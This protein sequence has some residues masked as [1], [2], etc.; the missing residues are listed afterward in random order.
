MFHIDF[1]F[2][3]GQDPK[4][5]PAPMRLTKEMVE[6]MGGPNSKNYEQ[7]ISLCFQV[8]RDVHALHCVLCCKPTG[9]CMHVLIACVHL[10]GAVM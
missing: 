3:F 1:G 4:I 2:I 8:M 9:A 10:G 5:Y 6:A 7:F